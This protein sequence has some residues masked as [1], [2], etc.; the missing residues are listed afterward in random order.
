MMAS[1]DSILSRLGADAQ[2]LCRRTWWVFLV[3][4]LAS[5]IFGVLAFVNP[6]IALL[7]LAMFFAASVLVDGVFS[8]AG[9]IQHR[10]KDGW[11]I[12]LLI[13]LLG[14]LVG[15]Y[16]LLNPP[17][18]ILAFI[19]LVAFQAIMLGVFTAMLGYKVR[20]ATRREWILYLTGGLSVLFGI[21]VAANPAAGSLSIVYLIAAWAVVIGALKI[22]F[23]LRVKNLH[24]RIGDRLGGLR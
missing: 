7:V 4:G 5:L 8:M 17:V 18:G 21:L 2:V 16:A 1:S 10:D 15:G 13:G 24:E 12:M 20:Q 11:W 23:G 3:G 22:A 9:A 6:G 14:L 19:Y